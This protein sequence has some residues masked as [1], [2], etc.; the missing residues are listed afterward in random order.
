MKKF[1][2]KIACAAAA[3]VMLAASQTVFAEFVDM[4][5]EP[6]MKA[7]LENAV[8]NGL[9]TGTSET[10]IAPYDAITRAEMGTIIV[11]CFGATETAD[12]SAFTDVPK[13]EWYYDYMSKAVAMG[14]FAGSGDNKLAPE[15]NITKQEA[16]IV[17]SRIF[18]I[19]DY[20]VKDLDV[21]AD[22]A[23]IDSWAEEYAAKIVSN[24]Y[25]TT[26]APLAPAAD[27]TRGE[28]AILMDNMV[29]EFID[30][31]GEYEALEDGNIVIRTADVTV[32]N[33]TNTGDVLI[34]DG[35]GA[36][37]VNFDTCVLNR[38]IARS[39][40]INA[41]GTKLAFGRLEKSGVTINCAGMVELSKTKI[42][43]ETGTIVNLGVQSVE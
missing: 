33:T 20:D 5:D 29:S 22:R 32:K 25:W 6:V 23:D 9:L 17:M 18:D 7:A 3:G 13:D 28:F 12:I 27:M 8:E 35:V 1:C 10:T 2:K 24:G 15:D 36:G 30:E 40:I 4:P 31:P 41:P 16:F 11:R 34:G 39:G 37:T 21:Y 38:L 14:A 19:Q 42:W 26:D 43:G